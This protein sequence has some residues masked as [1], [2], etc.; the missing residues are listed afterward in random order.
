MVGDG[1]PPERCLFVDDSA[2][3]VEAARAAGMRAVHFREF[4][5]LDDALR[6]LFAGPVG[7]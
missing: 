7:R 6:P 1:A 3:N 5:D 2:E 4:A